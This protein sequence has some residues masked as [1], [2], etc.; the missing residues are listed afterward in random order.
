MQ[1]L[2]TGGC[3]FIG[4]HTAVELLAE[5][6]EVVVVDNLSNSSETSVTQVEKISGKQLTFYKG[7]ICDKDKMN[8]IFTAHNFDCVMHFA[9]L[10]S[11][12]ESADQPILYYQINVNGTLVLLDV[13]K[14][15]N[16]K[17]I[18][19]SSSATVY[20]LPESLPIPETHPLSCTNPYG[21]TKLM[22]ED[23]LRDLG[24]SDAAW[25]VVILR[26]FNPVGAHPSGL[27]GENPNDIPNNLMPYISQTLVGK[28]KCLSIYGNNYNTIDGTGVRD[29]IHV[30]DLAQ[31]HVAALKR[32]AKEVITTSQGNLV[33]F[34]SN[35][36]EG[37][38]MDFDSAQGSLNTMTEAEEQQ[39]RA[40]CD[41]VH[42]YNLGTGKGFS[43]LQ[44]VEQMQI[45]AGKPIAHKF[46][47]RRVGDVG[48]CFSDP[49]KAQRE[50]DWVAKR[51]MAEMCE[52]T[53]RFQM[54]CID[55]SV[56]C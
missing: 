20:G 51:G 3:G 48:E 22:V 44:M 35:D 28:R 49:S 55:N 21:R 43:V 2:L 38:E 13:M 29:F 14:Q 40:K 26:Y 6:H 24:R 52:D 30:V 56:V 41:N 15:H 54:N 4:S 19:F 16:V 46:A 45:T 31:G 17:S 12:S 9:G 10:K 1:I 27:I 7:D 23:V 8:E 34:D 11:V 32:V 53:L 33:T 47:P 25:N 37:M 5:G 18:V 39:N 42:V 50:L 36:I